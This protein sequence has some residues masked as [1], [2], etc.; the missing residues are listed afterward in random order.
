M[1]NA[2]WFVF[3]ESWTKLT[4]WVEEIQL[5]V[6]E[7][8]RGKPSWVWCTIKHIKQHHENHKHESFYLTP[9]LFLDFTCS[10]KHEL[11]LD[12]WESKKFY[13]EKL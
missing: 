5:V 4:T 10:P 9:S 3:P 6:I 2:G 13:K 11:K 7:I 8:T 1:W 12:L